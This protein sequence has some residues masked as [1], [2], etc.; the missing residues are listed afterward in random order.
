MITIDKDKLCSSLDILKGDL[1]SRMIDDTCWEGC[2]S[3]SALSTATAVT[4]LAIFDRDKYRLQILNGLSWLSANINDDGGWG[5]TVKSLSNLPTTL[6]C[7][8][9]FAFAPDPD[10]YADAIE[11]V[12]GWL[13]SSVGSFDPE[14][15]SSAVEKQYGK[16]KTFSIPILTMCAIAGRL[17]DQQRAWKLV[18]PLPFE[19]AALPQRIFKW[20]HLSVVSYALPALIA[21]GQ[22]NYHRSPPQNIF[23]RLIRR[24][25]LRRTL[26]VLERIQPPHGGFLE[27]TP[28]TSFVV[29]SL[30]AAGNEDHSVVRKGI[31]FLVDSVLEDGSWPIDTNLSTWLTTLSVNALSAGRD[32]SDRQQENIT[33]WLLAQQYRTVHPYTNAPAG[34]WAWTDLPGGVPDADDTAGALLALA[35]LDP[36]I[37]DVDEAVIAGISW[38]LGLQN[39]DGGIPTFCSGWTKLPFDHSA[40]D[41]TAHA[42]AAIG[43]WQDKLS[44]AMSSK[45]KRAVRRMIAYL[46]DVQRTDG[47][48]VPLW[49]GNQHAVNQENPIYGTAKVLSF[50][51]AKYYDLPMLQKATAYIIQNQNDDGSWGARSSIEETA[52]CVDALAAAA[53]H[54]QGNDLP[55]LTRAIENGCSWLLDMI[56]EKRPLPA[57][58]IGLYFAKLWYYEELYPL[59]FTISA[60][61][62]VSGIK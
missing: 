20:M 3:S 35:N 34:G 27:A 39:R 12:E 49:F 6:L 15:I 14:T 44:P 23:A 62:R 29:M 47:S 21:I 8:C 56:G 43:S 7:Y 11:S 13:K 52:L 22:V 25:V 59:I 36:V 32:L 2:L 41:L 33:R 42:I 58:P 30:V 17:G 31:G 37:K 55:A 1:F 48:W 16:D 5:D 19:F 50:L 57:S 10:R 45:A 28:L 40:P 51:A 53:K 4:A 26:S 24:L 61:N 54:T 38:L 9:V 18:K 46:N 60:L